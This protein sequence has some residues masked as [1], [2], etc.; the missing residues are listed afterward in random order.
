MAI[1]D[2]LSLANDVAQKWPGGRGVF[3]TQSSNYNSGTA[4]LQMSMDGTNWIAV[5]DL[6]A[7]AA[8]STADG[9]FNVELPA[10]DVRVHETTGTPTSPTYQLDRTYGGKM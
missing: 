1:N 10:C 3:A 9:M 2:N 4:A 8:A 5:K 7:N 6:S